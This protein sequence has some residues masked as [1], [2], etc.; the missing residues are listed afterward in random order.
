MEFKYSDGG[1]A[2]AGY[3]GKASGD[4]FV[5]AVAIALDLPYD[6]VYSIVAE[7][8]NKTNPRKKKRRNHPAKGIYR[9]FADKILEEFG[10]EWVPTVMPGGRNY[11]KLRACDLPD[12]PIVARV[13]RHFCAVIDGTVY[14]DHDPTRGG[15][16]LVY[17]Y[18]RRRP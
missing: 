11:P 9:E 4:C 6:H 17:G 1:R 8:C 10:W 16:R 3:R 15:K 18:Y 13:S 14:D 5:R 12:G 7:R 2:K